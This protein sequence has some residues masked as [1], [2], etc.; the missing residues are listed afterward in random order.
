MLT[1]FPVF[2]ML[3]Y[4][5]LYTRKP[6]SRGNVMV[7]TAKSK[8]PRADFPLFPH[9][10]GYWA[11]KVRG[12]LHYFGKVAGDEKGQA[13]LNKWLAEKDDLLAGRTPRVK[14]DGL[15]VRD[16]CN[17][18]LTTK[19]MMADAGEITLRTFRDYHAASER[20][21]NVFG[22]DRMVLDL[23]AD[24]F[25]QLRAVL[26]KTMGHAARMVEIQRTRT[27]FKYAFDEGLIDRPVRYGT[28]FKAPSKRVMQKDR[29]KKG[30]R[31]LERDEIMAMLKVAT[32]PMKA[33][34]L[35]GVNCGFGNSDC[36]TLPMK[37][38]DL[39]MGWVDHPRPKT[40]TPRR[41]PLWPETTEALRAAIASRPTPKD[42]ENAGLVFITNYGKPWVRLVKSGWTDAVTGNTRL[43]L[44]A[45]GIKR[46]GV[47]F[48]SLRRT[49]ETIGGDSTDQ[50]AVDA[51]MGH[52]RNDMASVYRQRIEDA[53]LVAV[54]EH[55]RTWLFGDTK[56]K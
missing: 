24:D 31:M 3:T 33:M 52:S 9:V 50:V 6:N 26:D 5:R 16:L 30:S 17:R 11:K 20:V 51:I 49:T 2:D 37:A 13:A 55:V 44:K 4:T 12:K 43:L 19:R 54:V 42:S 21:V 40:G 32:I 53:R 38:L 8:K 23:A 15:T 56:Q 10:R 29:A 28:A 35:L 45:L 14:T 27:L 7:K 1:V 48:Y 25:Q 36:A 47:N 46:P 41:C 22:K 34:I 39:D 18:F